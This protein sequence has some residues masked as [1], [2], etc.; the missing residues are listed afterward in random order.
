L[1]LLDFVRDY[2]DEPTP[3]MYHQEGKTTLDLLE[4][5]IVSGSGIRWAIC[6]LTQTHKHASIPSLSFYRPDALPATQPT[7]SKYCVS[8]HQQ[9]K[10][11]WILMKQEMMRWQ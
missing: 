4:Q 10:P 8:Q 7:A 5:D 3:E 2:P 9:G 6:T 1:R 11:L